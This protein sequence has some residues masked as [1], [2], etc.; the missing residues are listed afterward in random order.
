MS[1][2][3]RWPFATFQTMSDNLTIDSVMEIQL[4]AEAW[5]VFDVAASAVSYPFNLYA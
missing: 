5:P 1:S 3:M 2:E 4:A